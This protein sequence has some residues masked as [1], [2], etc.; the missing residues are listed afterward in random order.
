MGIARTTRSDRRVGFP[1]RFGILMISPLLLLG[2]C[3]SPA[4]AQ[5]A[6]SRSVVGSGPTVSSAGTTVVAATLGQPAVGLVEQ[7]PLGV[8]QGFWG[9]ALLLSSVE[10]P[11]ITPVNGLGIS[12]PR[13]NPVVDHG[14]VTISIE[15]PVRLQALL[16]DGLGRPV[17]TVLDGLRS[18]GDHTV[19]FATDDLSSGL[20]HIRVMAGGEIRTVPVVVEQ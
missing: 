17:R 8:Y 4:D 15:R 16:V 12:Y 7:D 10:L 14:T 6:I 3:L 13:P 18:A 2:L 1:V 5:I 9:P 19:G 20:Y 11:R